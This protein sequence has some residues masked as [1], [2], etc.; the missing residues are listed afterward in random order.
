MRVV[1]IGGS[2]G[3]IEVLLAD[4]GGLPKDLPAFVLVTIHIGENSCSRLP[5]I[6]ARRGALPSAHT[7]DGEPALPGHIYVAPPGAHLLVRNGR[8]RL[9]AGPTINRHRPAID[10]RFASAARWCG[11]LA[12]AVV[13]SGLLGDG[14]M[15]AALIAGRRAGTRPGSPRGGIPLDA[16]R[17]AGGGA[18]HHSGRGTHIAGTIDELARGRGAEH[19][20]IGLPSTTT[21]QAIDSHWF[22]EL[23]EETLTG[24]TCP[25]C[26]GALA[27]FNVP[28]FSFYRCHV[29]HHYAPRS[30]ATAHRESAEAKLGAAVAA[31]EERAVLAHHLAEVHQ[32]LPR[33]HAEEPPISYCGS[34]ASP[35]LFAGSSWASAQRAPAHQ[36]KRIRRRCDHPVSR[37]GGARPHTEHL[38]AHDGSNAVRCLR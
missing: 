17:R 32:H 14:A 19:G 2:A 12:T 27:E 31:L 7:R 5:Q 8:L 28:D 25:E 18:G 30:L 9:S 20:P 37:V 11:D 26:G 22:T 38:A 34:A 29:G 3:G 1:T 6:L 15:G 13:L 35:T 33:G 23:D 10:A 24:S 21:P 4:V 36:E 16:A